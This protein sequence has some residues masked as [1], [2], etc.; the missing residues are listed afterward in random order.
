MDDVVI[1]QNRHH[2][3]AESLVAYAAEA[4]LRNYYPS[5]A[6]TLPT[7]DT[8]TKKQQGLCRHQLRVSQPSHDA[9]LVYDAVS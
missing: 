4:F 3:A 5:V 6:A 7:R 8:I 1:W 2:A 9:R